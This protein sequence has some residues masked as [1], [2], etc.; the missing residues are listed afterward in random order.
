MASSA[1]SAQRSPR[2]AS[3]SGVIGAGAAVS[4]EAVT[5]TAYTR[6]SDQSE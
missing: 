6:W 3:G 2:G 4:A 1:P 5:G